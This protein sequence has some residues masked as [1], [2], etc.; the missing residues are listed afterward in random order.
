ML[1]VE[2]SQRVIPSVQCNS[3]SVL[4]LLLT[5]L[6]PFTFYF[7]IIECIVEFITKSKFM[8]APESA[9][10]SYNSKQVLCFACLMRSKKLHKV[11]EIGRK[12]WSYC[13][14]KAPNI[15]LWRKHILFFLQTINTI[16]S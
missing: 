10:E 16:N 8:P 2:R 12:N 5:Y 9:C 4:R 13:V 6:K 3:S 1:G 15:T 11:Y 7:F 14:E